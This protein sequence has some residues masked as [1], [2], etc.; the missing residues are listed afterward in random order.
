M[1]QDYQCPKCLATHA[2]IIWTRCTEDDMGGP[3]M[4]LESADDADYMYTCPSCYEVVENKDLRI[5][6]V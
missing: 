2:D 4:P 3:V 1:L 6:T 5:L